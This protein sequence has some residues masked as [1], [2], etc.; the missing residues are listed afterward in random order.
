MKLI[1]T[2]STYVAIF[3]IVFAI[4]FSFATVFAS[5]VRAS[6]DTINSDGGDYNYGI[7]PM[8]LTYSTPLEITATDLGSDR[9]KITVFVDVKPSKGNVTYVD[10]ICI[11][12]KG[13]TVETGSA[14]YTNR[15][16]SKINGTGTKRKGEDAGN[17]SRISSS[18]NICFP[19]DLKS[20]FFNG[21]RR[22]DCDS[23]QL[24]AE[25]IVRVNGETRSQG[26]RGAYLHKNTPA[27]FSA[28]DLTVSDS[29][30]YLS[31]SGASS[32]LYSVT[33]QT[34]LKLKVLK[35]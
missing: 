4:C 35:K 16:Y 18:S 3:A 22:Y 34:L 14:S 32:G 11:Y 21:I 25:F 29:G 12:W 2:K 30:E 6:A 5:P 31:L 17:Y 26:L 19:L 13:Y 28:L 24:L 33:D 27:N 10:Q 15:W 9:Y 1:K 20:Y 7:A 8:S 23:S